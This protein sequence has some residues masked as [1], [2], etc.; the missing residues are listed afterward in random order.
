MNGAGEV[1]AYDSSGLS[2]RVVGVEAIDWVE[3]YGVD[4]DE[5]FS[6]AGSRYVD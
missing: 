4:F 1:A 6:W 2:E 3:S 5:D